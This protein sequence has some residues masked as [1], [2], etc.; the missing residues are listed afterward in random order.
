MLGMVCL[1]TSSLGRAAIEWESSEQRECAKVEDGSIVYVFG[2][3]NV[4]EQ[5]ALVQEVKA[6]CG[7]IVAAPDK[8][9]YSPGERGEI[10]AELF[11]GYHTG[12]IERT[13]VV[14]TDDKDEPVTKLKLIAEIPAILKMT[15]GKL[16]F[17]RGEAATVRKVKVK[18]VSTTP[19][20]VTGARS[21]EPVVKLSLATIKDGEEYELSVEPT[22]TNDGWFTTVVLTTDIKTSQGPKEVEY[23]VSN[24]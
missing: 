21:N 1:S 12:T 6:A 18:V 17:K 5:P 7:C 4:G 2:F 9:S 19:L 15:P 16:E 8:K 13:L 14:V 3:A 20:K 11:L 23:K 10:K 22:V 24:R